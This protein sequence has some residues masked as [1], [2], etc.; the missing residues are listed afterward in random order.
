MPGVERVRVPCCAPSKVLPLPVLHLVPGR[1]FWAP[2]LGFLFVVLE[3][4]CVWALLCVVC[5]GKINGYG[6]KLWLGVTV[7]TGHAP[8][9]RPRARLCFFFHNCL[10]A[11][12]VV[13]NANSA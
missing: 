12:C 13:N 10:D 9:M 5:G 1:A 3:T 6:L 4:G 2:G 8:A 11:A 7:F